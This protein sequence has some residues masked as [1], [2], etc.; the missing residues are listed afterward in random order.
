MAFIMTH[1]PP[2]LLPFSAAS[3]T[4]PQEA[5]LAMAD[6]IAATLSVA[7]TLLHSGRQIDL[8]GLDQM[9]GRLCASALDLPIEQGRTVRPRLAALLA[10]IDDLNKALPPP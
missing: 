5:V 10:S 8:T 6:G 9:T 7:R 3:A 4:A 1:P 2:L